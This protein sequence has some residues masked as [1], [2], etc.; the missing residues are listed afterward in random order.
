MSAL[1]DST[2]STMSPTSTLSP[3]A[4]SHSEILPS[5]IVDD[6]AGIMICAISTLGPAAAGSAAAGAAASGAAAAGAP[7][8]A[9]A[10]M[11]AALSQRIATGEPTGATSPSA[12]RIFAM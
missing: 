5:V 11:S 2:T 8:A 6:S 3:T 9:A 10:S 1:S 4:L 12:T 7:P